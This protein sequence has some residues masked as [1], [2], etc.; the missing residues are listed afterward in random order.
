VWVVAPTWVKPGVPLYDLTKARVIPLEQAVKPGKR[1]G[2]SSIWPAPDGGVFGNADCQGSD[3]RGIGH[4]SHLSDVYVYHLDAQGNLVWRAGKKASGIAKNG[5][6]YGR[7]TGLGG[8]IGDQYFD[9]SDEGG[10][11][12]I[13]TQDGL[14]VGRLLDDSATAAPSEYTL[15]VEHFGS[16]VYQ[17][18]LDKQW[19]FAAGASGYA[20]IW[21]IV[22]LDKVKRL[23]AKVKVRGA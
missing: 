18:A 13:Y 16:D 1:I 2:F 14:F 6:F 19:Y 3:P 4:S 20:S 11:E 5:E 15:L 17:S 22:G 23:A 8:A 21:Q 9:F 12:M 10:Q 7:A